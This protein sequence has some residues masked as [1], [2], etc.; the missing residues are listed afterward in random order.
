MRLRTQALPLFP[1]ALSVHAPQET[2]TR[3]LATSNDQT[4]EM[5]RFYVQEHAMQRGSNQQALAWP[6]ILSGLHKA[7]SVGGRFC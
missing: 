3:R 1:H 2:T 6:P 7:G 4:C 5:R